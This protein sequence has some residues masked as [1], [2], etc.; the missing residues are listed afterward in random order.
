MK[1][2]VGRLL[3]SRPGVRKE[4]CR[5]ACFAP[6]ATGAEAL[7]TDAVPAA[8]PEGIL[9]DDEVV[10]LMLRPSLLFIPLSC[11]TSLVFIAMIAFGLAY[12]AAQPWIGWTDTQAFALGA[13]LAA[14]RLS[15]QALEWYCRVYVLTDRRIIRRMG[16]LRIAI[17]E[18]RL[19]NIQHTAVFTRLRERA[20]GLGTIGFATSGTD[21]IEAMWV[22]IRR[23]FE[24][25]KTV[26]ETIRRYGQ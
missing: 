19:K 22:M 4:D 24:V 8:L 16:V 9:H 25:H 7:S 2:A 15:W 10:I 5:P 1:T 13:G 20:C 21:V 17:F 26:V 11:I 12:A 3:H 18:T 6:E 23:P 14:L